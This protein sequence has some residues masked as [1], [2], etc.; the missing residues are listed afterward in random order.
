MSKLTTT[1]K[2]NLIRIE[3]LIKNSDISCS[4]CNKPLPSWIEI[5]LID[6]CTRACI[7]CPKGNDH[8][9]PNQKFNF[10]PLELI[11]KIAADLKTVGFRGT[12]M[13]AG[14][15]EPLASPLFLGAVKEFSTISRVETV[16]NGDLLTGAKLEK[17]L[18]LG[19]SFVSVSVYDGPEQH[20]YLTNLFVKMGIPKTKYILRD[21]W[22]NSSKD[23]GVKLTN[24]AGVINV[25]NQDGLKKNQPCFYPHYSM[26]ID[27]NGDVFLCPQDWHRRVRCGNISFKSVH[28]V[29]VGS[30]YRKYR[31][32]LFKGDRS[33]FPC[34]ECNCSGNLHG[35]EQAEHWNETIK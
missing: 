10:M 12:I 4:C 18:D 9:A 24:R 33:L 8:I 5:S 29:W 14:Y 6:F 31:T 30:F 21:R 19:L 34:N 3:S 23:F 32:K 28:D 13:L 11:K 15:G 16:T 7:F 1:T 20:E 27:W 35:K 17:M 2:D 26:T 25:G 22:Y